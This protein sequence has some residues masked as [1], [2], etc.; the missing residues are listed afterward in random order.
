MEDLK[1]N[2]PQNKAIITETGNLGIWQQIY[3]REI[4]E[5]GHQIFRRTK[6]M[7]VGSGVVIHTSSTFF[8]TQGFN[9]PPN[10]S[11]ALVFI[12]GASIK[13]DAEGNK[14]IE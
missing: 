14:Y 11:E 10:T 13:E 12:P 6:A 2:E 7:Q 9:L 8:L 1:Q 3:S 4:K 5:N